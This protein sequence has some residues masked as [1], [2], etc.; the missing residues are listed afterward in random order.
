MHDY[1]NTLSFS[2]RKRLRPFEQK[3]AGR[4]NH[5]Y[6]KLTAAALTDEE[7]MKKRELCDLHY[8]TAVLRGGFSDVVIAENFAERNAAD[9][10][11]SE[12]RLKHN[13]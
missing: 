6:E 2:G 9:R 8:R 13:A 7:L 11:L 1:Q 5:Y 10:I 3:I 4:E 12:R